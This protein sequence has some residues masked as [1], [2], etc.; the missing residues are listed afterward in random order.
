MR[1]FLSSSYLQTGAKI[2]SGVGRITN[3]LLLKGQGSWVFTDKMKYLDFTVGIG[4][5]N[6]GHCHP[7]VVKA[8]QEQAGKFI[9][10]QIGCGYSE[11]MINLIDK[12]VGANIF[13]ISK[14]DSLFF[15]A[16]TGAEA[17]ENAAKV[18]RMYT[19]KQNI[20]AFQGG[21]HGRTLGTISLTTSKTIYGGR[22]GPFVPGIHFAPFPYS[23]QLPGVE[24]KDMVRHCLERFDMLLKQQTTPQDTAAVIIEPVL[25][26]GGYVPAPVE[27][28]KGLKERCDKHGILFIAD[29]VQTGF[30]RTGTMFYVEQAQI[31]PDILIS[32]KGLASG[33]P[34]SM[35][36]TKKKLMENQPAG[37]MGGTYA[38][39]PVSCASAIATLEVFEKEKVLENVNLRSKQ[40]FSELK[41]IQNQYDFIQ[42]VRGAGLMIG[43]EF[44]NKKSSQLIGPE[45]ARLA[46]QK[47]LMLMTTSAFDCLR[48]IPPLTISEQEVEIALDILKQCFQE[49]NQAQ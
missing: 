37:S 31:V 22:F 40:L 1:R 30:G 44:R 46:K 5:A 38:G 35:I 28:L 8:I 47:G 33:M 26:E 6:L 19:G 27:F 32:A 42:D 45:I 29:E 49:V 10:A 39:N 21:Y 36:V 24:Q 14:D 25:G 16:S 7:H 18:A 13:P 43:L 48:L 41:K 11:Q 3:D 9:H 15:F 17:V 4:V 23:T 34:L 12:L 2:S 20:I